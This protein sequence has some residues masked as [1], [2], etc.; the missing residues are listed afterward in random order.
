[1]DGD[2][3]QFD[4]GATISTIRRA[5]NGR[6]HHRVAQR[7]FLHPMARSSLADGRDLFRGDRSLV[8]A[9]ER[10][11]D[12]APRQE[13]PARGFLDHG[14]ETGDTLRDGAINVVSRERLRRGGERHCW[15]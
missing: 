4:F 6:R 1:M 15:L 10:A 8:G 13:T 14:F 12:V 3:L 7:N 11:T 9:S 5:A 2:A